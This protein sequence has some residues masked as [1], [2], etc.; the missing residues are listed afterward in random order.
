MQV[1]I[2]IYFPCHQ[3]DFSSLLNSPRDRPS[4]TAGSEPAIAWSALMRKWCVS[5]TLSQMSTLELVSNSKHI[6][7]N[8]IWPQVHF[9]ALHM[10]LAND[11][12]VSRICLPPRL[13][14]MFS[15][16]IWAEIIITSC[17]KAAGRKLILWIKLKQRQAANLWCDLNWY[18]NMRFL[19]SVF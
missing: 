9:S 15:S 19:L 1:S 18:K 3:K 16:L 5:V 10:T 8:T 13:Y 2:Q 4:V 6:G 12:F 7:H 11:R 17:I 14:K